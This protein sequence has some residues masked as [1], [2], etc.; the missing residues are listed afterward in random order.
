MRKGKETGLAQYSNNG[1]TKNDCWIMD[2]LMD[3]AERDCA[4]RHFYDNS[5]I[6][7]SPYENRRVCSVRT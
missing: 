4:K 3:H 5:Q 2:K 6:E 7:V 1:D